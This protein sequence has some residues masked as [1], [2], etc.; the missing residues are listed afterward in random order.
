MKKSLIILALPLC[1]L[2]ACSN[3]GGQKDTESSDTSY[4][5]DKANGYANPDAQTSAGDTSNVNNNGNNSGSI[6]SSDFLMQAADGG[7]AE[8][9]AGKMAQ[10]QAR[11]A[12]VKRFA[13][14]MVTDHT[15]ANAKV[16]SL[17][18]THNVNL[19]ATTSDHHKQ[20]AADMKQ[21]KGA[22]FDKAYMDMMVTDHQATIALFE[23]A[24]GAPDDDVKQFA[25]ET[26]PKLRMHLDSAQ[27]VRSRLQ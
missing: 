4:D 10:K 14:M 23:R 26:L 6:S 11:D 21:K 16:K 8:V 5:K 20:M 18:A 12:G 7:M 15:A 25:N 17:A 3:E 9:E 27:A 1:F 19:P 2:F 13:T 24:T 22:D